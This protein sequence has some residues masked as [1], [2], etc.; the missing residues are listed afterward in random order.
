MKKIKFILVNLIIYVQ[1]LKNVVILHKLLHMYQIQIIH[2]E[3]KILNNVFH[4]VLELIML[5]I[6]W[7]RFVQNILTVKIL[8]VINIST[9]HIVVQTICV[10]NNVQT[11]KCGLFI[12][13]KR[14]VGQILIIVLVLIMEANTENINMLDL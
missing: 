12:V 11:M 14:I 1:N 6:T 5:M 10:L 2:S 7:K 4:H 3:H 8:Q 9:V 13:V